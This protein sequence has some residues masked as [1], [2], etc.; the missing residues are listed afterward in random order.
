WHENLICLMT[1]LL[2]S[3]Q[4]RD[5]AL[6]VVLRMVE[7]ATRF[8]ELVP[9]GRLQIWH[10][11]LATAN[12]ALLEALLASPRSLRALTRAHRRDNDANRTARGLG[13][14]LELAPLLAIEGLVDAPA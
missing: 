14:L 8:P 6:P 3:A 4:R 12:P 9:G 13:A 2:E 5:D 1:A 7:L 11:L 10:E